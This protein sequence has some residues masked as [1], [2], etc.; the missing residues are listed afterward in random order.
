MCY[1]GRGIHDGRLGQD[2]DAGSLARAKEIRGEL[3]MVFGTN[4]PHVPGAGREIIDRALQRSAVRYKTLLY[5]AEHAFTRDE[6]PRFDPEVIDLAFAEL[7]VF[8]DLATL[9]RSRRARTLSASKPVAARQRSMP[10]CLLPDE[11]QKGIAIQGKPQVQRRKMRLTKKT[12][13]QTFAKCV[14][15][16]PHGSDAPIRWHLSDIFDHNYTDT[17][18]VP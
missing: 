4:D 14:S 8:P 3:L 5:P 10:R 9:K 1:Y 2:A 15:F 7:V 16:V 12:R 17:F 18:Q 6:G 13:V 11:L